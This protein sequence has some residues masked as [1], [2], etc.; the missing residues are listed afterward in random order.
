M[1][2][3]CADSNAMYSRAERVFNIE[4]YFALKSFVTFREA[5]NKTV[6]Q[7]LILKGRDTGNVCDECLS[8]DK[9]KL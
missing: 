1:G 9:T 2:K 4:H 6:K 3:S 7:Q 5:P 8:S